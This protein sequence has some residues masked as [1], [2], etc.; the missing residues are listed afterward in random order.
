MKL[1]CA[2]LWVFPP[3][4]LCFSPEE[5]HGFGSWC[6]VIM[7]KPSGPSDEYRPRAESPKS[8]TGREFD[9]FNML[10]WETFCGHTSCIRLGQSGFSSFVAGSG[11]SMFFDRC[12]FGLKF[13]ALLIIVLFA[14]KCRMASLH[15]RFHVLDLSHCVNC[16]TVPIVG[17][18]Y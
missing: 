17:N 16:I 8:A 4:R 9:V 3:Q 13:Q 6:L 15:L 1:R 7:P 10:G 12:S 5:N 18:H 2:F 11:S 14:L